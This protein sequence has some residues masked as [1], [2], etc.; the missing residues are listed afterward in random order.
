MF[1]RL[2]DALRL[3]GDLLEEF[4]RL[5]PHLIVPRGVNDAIARYPQQP[6]FRFFGNAIHWPFLQRRNECFAQPVFRFGNIAGARHDVGDE[7]AVQ[8]ACDSFNP[9]VRDVFAHR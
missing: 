2:H 7:L 4:L 5:L 3:F 9:R 6:R 1:A 8:I